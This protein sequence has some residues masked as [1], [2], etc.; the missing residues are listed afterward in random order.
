MHPRCTPE[1]RPLTGRAYPLTELK[2]TES[3]IVRQL[4]G[5]V[6]FRSRLASL[7]FTPGAQITMLRNMGH[8]P[9]IVRLRGTRIAL[10]RGEAH[11]ILVEA[12]KGRK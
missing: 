10:G 11:K 12:D 9:V 5:G 3:A 6:G 4:S 8:G 2:S 1:Q 7:G